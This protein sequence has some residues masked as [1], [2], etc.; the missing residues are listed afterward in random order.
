MDRVRAGKCMLTLNWLGVKISLS[1][2]GSEN[3]ALTGRESENSVS[4][5]VRASIYST[6]FFRVSL[7]SK[8]SV[9]SQ[10]RP[11]LPPLP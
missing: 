7:S 10:I 5:R 3:L 11:Y 2:G 8:P 9:R 4:H 6:A 1:L